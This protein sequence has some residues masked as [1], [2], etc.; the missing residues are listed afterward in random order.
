MAKYVHLFGTGWF[1]VK[2]NTRY[3]VLLAITC[4]VILF[5][6]FYPS[7]IGG[8]N[9]SS[10]CTHVFFVLTVKYSL[11]CFEV[12]TDQLDGGLVSFYLFR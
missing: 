4:V 5:T 10:L 11:N 3:H 8:N 2:N 9:R 1:S 6:I 7:Q 12:E